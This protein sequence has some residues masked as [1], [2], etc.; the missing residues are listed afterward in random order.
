MTPRQIQAFAGQVADQMPNDLEMADLRFSSPHLQVGSSPLPMRLRL[1]TPWAQSNRKE[2]AMN[3]HL[4]WLIRTGIAAISL[5]PL[6]ET[7]RRNGWL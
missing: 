3:P 1:A 6:I 2:I 4:R 7:G 5:V